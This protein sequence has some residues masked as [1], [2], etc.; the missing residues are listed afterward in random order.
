MQANKPCTFFMHPLQYFKDLILRNN[1]LNEKL[2]FMLGADFSPV[3]KRDFQN[4]TIEYAVTNAL[5]EANDV[6]VETITFAGYLEEKIAGEMINSFDLIDNAILAIDDDKKQ[7]LYLKTLYKTFNSLIL[8]AERL[9]YTHKYIFIANCLKDL[10]TELLDK[11]NVPDDTETQK[12][13]NLSSSSKSSHKLQWM[14]K[15]K[16]LITLFYDLYSNV[17]NS[18]EPFIRASK[19]QIKNFLLNNFIE[20]DGQPLS[21]SSIDTILTPSKEDKRALK[22]D[23]IDISKLKEE[24]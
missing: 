3:I 23:R 14:G 4:D 20:K 8:Y 12:Q 13:I 2:K 5:E 22:G 18:G 15:S 19:E 7:S 24:K 16:I 17:E 6:R 11:Y 9:D 1:I 21:A 10:K